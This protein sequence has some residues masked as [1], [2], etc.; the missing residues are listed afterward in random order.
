MLVNTVN[1]DFQN[2][3][4]QFPDRFVDRQILTIFFNKGCEKCADVHVFQHLS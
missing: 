4:E 1:H 3:K 2:L